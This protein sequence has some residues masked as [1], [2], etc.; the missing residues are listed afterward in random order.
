MRNNAIFAGILVVAMLGLTASADAL[1]FDSFTDTESVCP[2]C[3][4]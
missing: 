3:E 1:E 4:L 2:D